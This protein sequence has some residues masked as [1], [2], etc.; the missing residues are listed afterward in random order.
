MKRRRSLT[1]WLLINNVPTSVPFDSGATFSFIPSTA[2]TLWN[3]LVIDIDVGFEVETVVGKPVRVDKVVHDSYIE[4]EGHKFH[5]RLYVLSLGGFDVVL[6]M[7]WLASFE[8]NILCK[9]KEI[10]SRIHMEVK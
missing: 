2:C 8:A 10:V 6:G 4:L 7:D 5:V 3:L 9:Q 1:L